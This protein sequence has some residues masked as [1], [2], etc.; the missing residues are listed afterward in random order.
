MFELKEWPE[1]VGQTFEEA[2]QVI[3]KFDG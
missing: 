2:S 3:L 1:L